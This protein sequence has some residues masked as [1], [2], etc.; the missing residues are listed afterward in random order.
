MSET[1]ATSEGLMPPDEALVAGISEAALRALSS[2]L[3]EGKNVPHSAEML[4]EIYRVCKGPKGLAALLMKQYIDIEPGKPGRT[5]ILEAII[6]T[7]VQ[8]TQLGGANKPLHLMSD[9][10]LEAEMNRRMEKIYNE[11]KLKVVDAA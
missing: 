2:T 6:R 1:V 9:D 8:N 3:D 5:R 4:E 11:A 7:T 10:E